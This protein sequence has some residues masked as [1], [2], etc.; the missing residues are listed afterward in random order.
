MSD[1]GRTRN[2]RALVCLL[3]FVLVRDLAL[4]GEQLSAPVTILRAGASV[5]LQTSTFRVTSAEEVMATVDPFGA[6]KESDR[7][8]NSLRALLSPGQPAVQSEGKSQP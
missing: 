5:T 6:I 2:H 4:S 8:N 7:S 1:Y 3:L